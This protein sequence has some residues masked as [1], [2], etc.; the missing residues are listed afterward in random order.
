MTYF[1]VDGAFGSNFFRLGEVDDDV[2][3]CGLE[4]AA[5]SLLE[6]ELLFS[7]ASILLH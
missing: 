5:V 3:G 1:D 6:S 7:P 4:S 2:V